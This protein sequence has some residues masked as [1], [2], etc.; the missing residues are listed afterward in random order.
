MSESATPTHGAGIE[1]DKRTK[2]ASEQNILVHNATLRFDAFGNLSHIE[3]TV[4]NNNPSTDDGPT[5][6]NVMVSANGYRATGGSCEDMAY[7]SPEGGCKHM[8]YVEAVISVAFH[9][10]Y[11]ESEEELETQYSGLQELVKR[12]QE[13]DNPDI[14]AEMAGIDDRLLDSVAIVGESCKMELEAIVTALKR[15]QNAQ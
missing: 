11:S 9:L 7:H 13:S 3:V 2:R 10:I 12:V 14:V 8:R 1:I 15:A 6:H 5:S 4:I